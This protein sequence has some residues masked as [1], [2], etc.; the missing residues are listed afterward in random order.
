MAFEKFPSDE[1][2]GISQ[3]V[4]EAASKI[5]QQYAMTTDQAIKIVEIA[6]IATKADV[7]NE[8]TRCMEDGVKLDI[9]NT[10]G[11]PFNV[12]VN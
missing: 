4:A 7:L 5:K 3:Q 10:K 11:Y 6:A 8:L 12:T 1:L 9:D 2:F